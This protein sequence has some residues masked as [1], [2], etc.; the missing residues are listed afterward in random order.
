[1]KRYI[2]KILLISFIL[3]LQNRMIYS[4][5]H[6]RDNSHYYKHTVA[7]QACTLHVKQEQE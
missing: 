4:K 1:M 5:E 2:M 3:A 7:L 6:R